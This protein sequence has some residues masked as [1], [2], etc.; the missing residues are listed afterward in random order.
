MKKVNCV[1]AESAENLTFDKNIAD[2]RTEKTTVQ[3]Y[4]QEKYGITLR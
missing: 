4:F 3:N 2:G 1:T